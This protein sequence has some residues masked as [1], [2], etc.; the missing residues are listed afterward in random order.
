MKTDNTEIIKITDVI[1]LNTT[2][3]N[4]SEVSMLAIQIA[5]ET[6]SATYKLQASCDEGEVTAGGVVT[7]VSTWSDIA[8]S[9]QALNAGDNLIYD[10]VNNGYNWL[11]VVVTGSGTARGRINTK[12]V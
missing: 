1:P 4:T 9:T 3:Y 8:G 7:K 6:G 2:P 12:G 11:R 10:Y 5:Q